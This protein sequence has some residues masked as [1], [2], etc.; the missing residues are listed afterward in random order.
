MNASDS[1]GR[2]RQEIVIAVVERDGM[3]LIGRR[4]EGAS[5]GGYWEFPGGKLESGETPEGAAARE[6]LEETG[7]EVRVTG[8]YPTTSH[9]YD[10]AAVRLHFL[11]CEVVG[12][13]H[14]LPD[15][16]RWVAPGDLRDYRFPPANRE[17]LQLLIAGKSE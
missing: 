17:L 9:D 7:L 12:Q 2:P 8:A 13:Q 14:A 11:A 16:F 15:R 4:A 10:H 6:C 3:F 1:A 5:L